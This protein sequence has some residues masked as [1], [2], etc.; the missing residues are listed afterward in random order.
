MQSHWDSFLHTP[1]HNSQG[2]LLQALVTGL[3]VWEE[4][5]MAFTFRFRRRSNISGCDSELIIKF[6]CV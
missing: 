3:C 6:L 2:V 1:R 4:C 5:A